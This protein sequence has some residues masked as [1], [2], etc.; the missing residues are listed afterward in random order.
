MP[1][2]PTLAGVQTKHYRLTM[3]YEVTVVM[4][5]IPMK[6]SVHTV[7][8]AWTTERFGNVAHDILASGMRT[9]NPEVD[10]LLDLE[11]TKIPGFPLRQTSSIR[12]TLLNRS[13]SSRVQINPTRTIIREMQ[14]N[15]IREILTTAMVF[16]VPAGFT[17]AKSEDRP[18]VATEVLSMQPSGQ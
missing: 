6:Q 1:D 13:T 2:L 16:T 12:T 7:I 4:R 15:S 11:T 3:D 18:N 14:V 8:D 10:R 17:R 9:G 5:S